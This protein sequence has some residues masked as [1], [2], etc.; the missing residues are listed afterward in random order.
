MS[1]LCFLFHLSCVSVCLCLAF[2]FI[3]LR[4]STYLRLSLGV[5]FSMIFLRFFIRAL[6]GDDILGFFCFLVYFAMLVVLCC[7]IS[8]SSSSSDASLFFS[9]S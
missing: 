7:F 4:I 6:V 3:V 5:L 1:Q 9:T 8:D 2:F